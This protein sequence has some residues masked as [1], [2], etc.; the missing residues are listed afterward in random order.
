MNKK[1]LIAIGAA[2][3]FAVGVVSWLIFGGK[4]VRVPVGKNTTLQIAATMKNSVITRESEGKKLWEFTVGEAQA[5]K[6][7]NNLILK[8]IK[9]KVYQKDG[10]VIDIS[11][12]RGVIVNSKNSFALA[13][14]VKAVDSK[15]TVFTCDKINYKQDKNEN[16]ITATGHV[17]MTKGENKASADWASTTTAFEVVKMKGNAKVE[18]GGN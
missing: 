16:V 3:L 13:G 1:M 17:V 6:N 4:A 10:G 5:D 8:G 7:K 15:G 11:A 12:D 14:H 18:K 2:L 9:G